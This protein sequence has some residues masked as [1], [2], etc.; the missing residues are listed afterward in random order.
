[1]RGGLCYGE[2]MNYRAFVLVVFSACLLVGGCATKPS[3]PRKVVT[4]ESRK[5]IE[6]SDSSGRVSIVVKEPSTIV[7]IDGRRFVCRDYAGYIAR[8]NPGKGW[9]KVG[10]LDMSYD[11]QKIWIRGKKRW[12]TFDRLGSQSYFAKQDGSVGRSVFKD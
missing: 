9:I 3:G 5:P 11:S 4:V 7:E 12:T 1:M 6:V 10:R 2:D 8:I